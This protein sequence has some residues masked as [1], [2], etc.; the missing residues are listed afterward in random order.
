MKRQWLIIMVTAEVAFACAMTLW[1]GSS[2]EDGVEPYQFETQDGHTVEAE[3]GRFSVPEDRSREGSRTIQLEFVRFKSTSA[4]PGSPIVYLAGGPGGSGIDTARGARFPVFMAMRDHADVIA[5]DQRGTGRS[6][7]EDLDC[8]DPYLIPFDEPLDRKK[9]GRIVARATAGCVERLR[10]AGIAVSAYHTRESAA[11]LMALREFLGAKKISLWGISYGTHLAL[12]AAKY[13]PD[14]IDRMV[15][16]GIEGP[17]EAYKLP[18]AQQALMEVIADR[19]KAD[20]E[21]GPLVPDL[22][23]SIG[24][25]LAELGARP[26]TVRLA[27]PLSGE[28]ADVRVGSLDLQVVLANMLRGP[29]SFAVMPDLIHRLEQ[30]DWTALALTAARV[31][32]GE[33]LHGMTLAM[34]CSSGAGGERLERIAEQAKTTLLGDAI[35][36]PFPEV[37]EGQNLTDLGDE[38]RKPTVS[39]IP[40]LLISGTLD[41]RTPVKNGERAAAGLA[42]AHHLIVEGAGHGDPLFLS[43]PRILEAMHTF[44]KAQTVPYRRI[45]LPADEFRPTPQDHPAHGTSPRTVRGFVPDPR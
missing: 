41:G 39:D 43:S 30:G 18:E 33:G 1:G 29:E 37:C 42:N 11:D 15:L 38:F 40:S 13:H 12:T 35:N 16:A 36:L 6:G 25:L 14:G 7:F 22:L 9:A 5:L 23:G 34:D 24:R 31:R 27:H 8:D 20:P 44:M 17:D 2:H 28:E 4:N 19:V 21:V 45:E 32:I 26:K 10:E 3:L